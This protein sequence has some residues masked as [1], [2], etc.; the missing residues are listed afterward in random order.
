MAESGNDQPKLLPDTNQTENNVNFLLNLHGLH[1]REEL[2]V[3]LLKEFKNK[4]IKEQLR[5]RKILVLRGVNPTG[6]EDWFPSACILQVNDHLEVCIQEGLLRDIDTERL[7]DNVLNPRRNK[8]TEE[9]VISALGHELAHS[10]FYDITKSPP[11]RYL[12]HICHDPFEESFCLDFERAWLYQ[13]IDNE[14]RY[15]ETLDLFDELKKAPNKEIR[16]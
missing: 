10:F 15:K 13:L 2:I 11:E 1:S 6:Y 5:A 16:L 12:K 7:P 9:L 4:P 3:K 8:L 14:E